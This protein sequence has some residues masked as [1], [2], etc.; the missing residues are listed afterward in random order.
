MLPERT[1]TLEERMRQ[2]RLEKERRALAYLREQQE[3]RNELLL[4][5]QEEKRRQWVEPRICDTCNDIDVDGINS[6]QVLEAINIKPLLPFTLAKS[7]QD[8]YQARVL[9]FTKPQQDS[10]P[11]DGHY[12]VGDQNLHLHLS[13]ECPKHFVVCANGCGVENLTLQN[14]RCHLRYTCPRRKVTCPMCS[15]GSQV[16]LPP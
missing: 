9:T 10:T 15:D 14:E 5:E 8:H 6:E 2:K 13:D 4:H 12:L 1:S 3:E 7:K 16:Q 11:L